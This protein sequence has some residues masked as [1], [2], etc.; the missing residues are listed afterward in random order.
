MATDCMAEFYSISEAESQRAYIGVRRAAK[1]VGFFLPHLRPGFSVLDC[2]CGVGSITLDIAELVAPG[3]VVGLDMDESQLALAREAAI[4]RGLSNVTFQRGDIR[5]LPF[6]EGTFDAVLAHTL[7]FH[8]RRPLD[9]LRSIRRALKPGGVAAISDDDYRTVTYSPD[10]PTMQRLIDLWARVVQHN[11]GSPYYSRQFAG[12]APGGR[13]RPDGRFRRGRRLLR[14][15]GRDS[16]LCLHYEQAVAE[17]ARRRPGRAARTGRSRRSCTN[18]PIG[19][20]VGAS[21]PTPSSPSPIVP[22]WDGRDRSK[23][24]IRCFCRLSGRPVQW[25]QR[26]Q[27]DGLSRTYRS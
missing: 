21:V 5:R 3:R 2:G 23:C 19:C 12:H 24:C 1:W 9:A 10:D 18:W 16:P 27:T 15:A 26:R 17:P 4:Q 8:L 22:P 13:I 25:G 7:L 20:N 11:G 6:A 14:R